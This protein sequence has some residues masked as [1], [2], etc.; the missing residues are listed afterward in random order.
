MIPSLDSLRTFSMAYIE[1]NVWPE[2]EEGEESERGV[3]CESELGIA[4]RFH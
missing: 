3:S 4:R 2:E 1:M